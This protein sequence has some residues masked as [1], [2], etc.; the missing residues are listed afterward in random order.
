M[1]K[2]SF[3]MGVSLDGYI[4]GRDDDIN[5]TAPD[6][7]LFRF[8]TERVRSADVQL[9]GRKL[10]EVMRYWE[11]AGEKPSASADELEFARIWNSIRKIV[12]SRT[13]ETLEGDGELARADVAEVIARLRAEPGGEI[14][15]GGAGLAASCMA[16]GL[17]DELNLFVHPIVLGSGTPYFPPLDE[18]IELR[19]VETRRFPSEVVLLRYDVVRDGR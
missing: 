13:L 12:F 9:C 1:R 4:A 8:H 2:V 3:G 14:H 7:E 19:L 6:E 10:Y 18:R 15:V 16:Q 5:W 17:L 11:T